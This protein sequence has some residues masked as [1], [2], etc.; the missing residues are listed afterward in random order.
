MHTGGVYGVAAA[1]FNPALSALYPS[2]VS[3]DNY[4]AANSLRQIVSQVAI[5]GGP[6]LGGYL[7]AQ[8]SVGLAFAFD[9]LTFVISFLALLLTRRKTFQIPDVDRPK[10]R[11][12]SVR[13]QWREIFGGVRFL[14]GEIS[15]LSL[16]I[17]FSLVNGLNNVEAVLVP[18]LVRT[19]LGLPATAFGLLASAMGAGTLLGAIVTG[20][21]AGRVHRR[22]QVICLAMLVFGVA[23]IAMGLANTALMLDIA[24][25][26]LGLSFIVPEVMFTSLL[27]LVIPAA[28]RGR[29]FSVLTL[30]AMAMN[31]LGLALAGVLG[32]A[33][34]TR[35]GLWMG[36][37]AIGVLSVL[38][39]AL[40]NVRALNTRD[41]MAN[42]ATTTVSPELSAQTGA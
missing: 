16:I 32:D 4:D 30:I 1:F 39:L 11:S 5:L 36:G 41:V 40:P 23:I 10:A 17:F 15:I 18:R 34:G 24:Y 9:A 26:V 25:F 8:S 35:A 37:G 3:P 21:V 22:A 20:L 2:L 12:G 29:V 6:A 13:R 27:Q 33:F 38:A 28:M 42:E 7:I 31:P 14:K 19:E